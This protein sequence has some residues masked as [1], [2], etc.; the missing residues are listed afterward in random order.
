[1]KEMGKFL[2][3][4]VFFALN[5]GAIYWISTFCNIYYVLGAAGLSIVLWVSDWHL[6]KRNMKILNKQRKMAK[7]QMK[8][9]SSN[10]QNTRG[11][12]KEH[13]NYRDYDRNNR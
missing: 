9:N 4:L 5:I 12:M 3:L 2:L 10:V 1:M 13:T 6:R 8:Q 7:K 11:Q